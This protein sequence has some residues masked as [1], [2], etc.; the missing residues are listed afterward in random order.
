M[1]SAG[2]VGTA[3]F[4]GMSWNFGFGSDLFLTNRLLLQATVLYRWMTFDQGA[5]FGS[6]WLKVGERVRADGLHASVG[7][8]FDFL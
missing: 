1:S 6:R 3:K 5:A 2:Q 7:V 8:A 4:N